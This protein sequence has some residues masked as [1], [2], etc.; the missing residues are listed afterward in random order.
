M[1]SAIAFAQGASTASISGVVV[2]SDGGVVPGA[3]VAVKNNATGETFTAVTSGQGVFSVPSLIT[4]AYTV[5]VSLQGFKTVILNNVVVNAGVPASVRATLEIGGLTE[6]VVVQSNAELVQT[7]SATVAT[8]LDTRQVSSLP[9]SSRN[10][11]DFIVF[12][13]GVTTPGGSRD[14]I[15]NGLPQSTINMTLDGV[16]IQDNTLKSTDGF[17]AIVGPR[18]DA[19]EEITVTTAATGADGTGAGATQIR[20]VTRSGTNQFRGSLFHTYRSDTLNANT[21]FNKRDNLPKA[22]LLQNQPGFNVGGPIM[23]PGFN[24]R[25][26]AFFF[27]NYEEFRQPSGLRRNRTILHPLAQQGN[28][29]Y[30][31]SQGVRSVN[32][33]DLAARAGHTSTPD[34]IVSGLLADIRTATAQEGNVRDLPDPLYQQYSYLVPTESMNRYPTLRVDYQVNDRHRLTYSFNFQYVGGGPDTTNNREAYFPGFPVVA[35]QGSVRRATSGWLRSILTSNLV[36]EF[37]IGYGGAPVVFGQNEFD[38]SMWN[39]S[40]ANQGGFHL[41]M[42]EALGFTAAAGFNA[43]NAGATSARDAFHRSIENTLNWQKGAHSF[44]VGGAFT[45]Y[46]IWLENQQV[47][48]E[49]RFGVVTGDPAESLFTQANFPGASTTNLNNARALYAILTGRI[50]EFRYTARLNEET[51]EYEALGQ[52]TQRARQRQ[53]GFWAQDSWRVGPNLTLNYGLR[54]DLQFPFIALNNSYSI[55]DLE[56]VY[57]R[58]GIGNLFAPG[59]LAGR[60]PQFRQLGEGERPYGMDWNNVAPS[61]GFAWTPSAR[62]GFL[63]RIVGEPGDMAIRAGYSRSFTRLGLNDFTGEVGDNPGVSLS[64]F[65]NLT[66]GNLGPLPVLLRDTSRLGPAD[67][68]RT[69]V[70]P[71]RDVVGGDVT[72]FSPDLVVPLSDTWQAGVTRALGRSMSVEARYLGARSS[73]NW[74]TNNYNELNIVENGFLDEFRV[75]MTNLQANNAAGGARVGSFAYFGPGTGTA[76]LP[77]FLAHFNGVAQ[78]GAGNPALYTSANF[79]NNTY[80]TSLARF[81]P[82][83]YVAADALTNDAAARARALAAGLPPNF[84]VVNPDLLGGALIVENEGRT[85]YNSLGLELKRRSANGLSFASSYVLGHA[86]QSRFLSLRVDSPMVRN[87]GAEGDVTHAFK[88]N[89][90]YALPFGRGQRFGSGVNGFLDRLIGGWQVAGNARVQSGRLLDLGN[91]R[92]VG[93]TPTELSKLFKLRI[94]SDGSVFMLPDEIINESVKAFSVSATS[95]TG[96]SNLG[97]PSGRYIAP[98]D[99]F[100]CVETVRGEG[101][102]GL[103][104]VVVTGPLFKQFDLSIVKRVDIVGRVN[105]EFRL[106]ALNVFDH[107]NFAPVSGI[108]I[109]TT[110]A[111]FNRSSG[112]NPN[113]YEVNALTGTNTARVLQLVARVRW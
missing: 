15:V 2:D 100:D 36:N 50:D 45:E 31:T 23:L 68:P 109:P 90:V 97:P 99:S 41:N 76:P 14:S 8:T 67:F 80:L 38:P 101:R 65:R 1:T 82:G 96:Y 7:S 19:V 30:S 29:R 83:P 39:G 56:D 22:E 104:S 44:N 12:L 75:A 20:Y 43:G 49:L 55:G 25:N 70:F 64:A 74:R 54:Y 57:G 48:P 28:F 47:V 105:A 35:N 94:A 3:D 93:M 16:N 106:D 32:L 34:P 111:N 61:V 71:F 6:Q 79:R 91:V 77:I 89:A 86:T 40:V 10:A 72:I 69:P 103:Q 24:G 9:L 58:S 42:S 108:T 17:F 85:M 63:G 87:D 84:F 5:T 81:N 53:I 88:L 78:S 51:G 112:S 46:E 13:P 73:G 92:L 102:C 37:R 18:L 27:F 60:V 21:W 33:F 95:A 52:G 98:A 113:T 11:A 66:N 110:G 59:T 62:E 4:G 107:V 26:R